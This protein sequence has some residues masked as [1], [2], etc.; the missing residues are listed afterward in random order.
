MTGADVKLQNWFYLSSD[1]VY[2]DKLKLRATLTEVQLWTVKNKIKNKSK[3]NY[4]CTAAEE[5]EAL[6]IL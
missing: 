3:K 4:I 5:F 2:Q 1:Q 6:P